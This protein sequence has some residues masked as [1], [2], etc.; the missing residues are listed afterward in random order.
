MKK[1]LITLTAIFVLASCS[2]DNGSG[3]VTKRDTTYP[4]AIYMGYGLKG[5]EGPAIVR[6]V[7]IKDTLVWEIGKDST[8]AKKHWIDSVYF[9][10]SASV[11]VKDA[12][13]AKAFGIPVADSAKIDT[14]IKRVFFATKSHVREFGG[15]DSAIAQ[16]SRLIDTTKKSQ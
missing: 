2:N 1:G 4:V 3:K 16:L 9:D 7:T 8:S 14:V 5:I 15:Y 13:T 6:K 12:K 10:V 11:L